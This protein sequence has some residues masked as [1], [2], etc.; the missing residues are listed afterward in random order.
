MIAVFFVTTPFLLIFSRNQWRGLRDQFLSSL[1]SIQNWW[2]IQQGNSYFANMGG[3]SPFKHLYY[4]S[5][6]MQ[7]FLIWPL[8]LWLLLL[9]FRKRKAIFWIL[10]GLAAI[11]A[12]E[13]A[14]LFVPGADPTRVYYGTDTRA[15]SLLM[16]AGLAMLCPLSRKWP[17]AKLKKQGQVAVT[18]FGILLL[19]LYVA[20]NLWMPAQGNLTYRG[21]LFAVSLLCMLLIALVLHPQ[22]GLNRIL[23]NPV[24]D[25]VGSRAFGIYLWQ[26]PIFALVESRL[27]HPTIWYNVIWQLVLVLALAELSYRFVEQP[28]MKF[29]FSKSFVVA[30]SFIFGGG[31][32]T[33]TKRGQAALV[34]V[35]L[36]L[37]LAS[38]ASPRDQ[39]LL[40]QRILA[41]QAR[42]AKEQLAAANAKVSTPLKTVA[43]KYGAQPVVAEKASQMRVVAIGDSV[44]VA[45]SSGLQEMFPKIQIS[46]TVGEQAKTGESYLAKNAAQVSQADAILVG[47]GTN[48][49]LTFNGINYIDEIMTD[50]KG[51]PV[52]WINNRAPGKP[53]IPSNN[54]LLA[55]AAKRYK[56]LTIIDW[57]GTSEGHAS[58]FYSDMIHPQDEGVVHYT[59][60]VADQMA[61]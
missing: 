7:F 39:E 30:K 46:A 40:Q 9:I 19:L 27:L 24:F 25:Y 14:I 60:L 53:W 10:M 36:G 15:F 26:L 54:A 18:G 33:W 43:Q 31:W 2:Q 38:P 44:M 58:W 48:G 1:L 20:A 11:S 51:K 37:I 17:F 50:A 41:Q 49:L 57:Y 32:R 35:I 61:R 22:V 3:E 4:L 28:A 45:A 55:A 42:L 12:V 6:E 52:Y 47:L 5:I 56:N 13:M 8:L 23:S 59:K 29:D 21:G 34:L 16:G